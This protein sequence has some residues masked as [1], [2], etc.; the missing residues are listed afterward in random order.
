MLLLAGVAFTWLLSIEDNPP[1]FS[2]LL[3]VP[4]IGGLE[5]G[6]NAGRFARTFS[7]VTASGVPVLEALRIASQVM[8]NVPM[9]EAVEE[10]A[11]GA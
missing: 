2:S 4:L 3:L 11:R 5:R 10:A 1:A 8:S 6:V 9:R 7:I